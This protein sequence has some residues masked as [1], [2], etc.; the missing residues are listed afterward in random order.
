MFCTNTKTKLECYKSDD[1]LILY[2][3]IY[4]FLFLSFC[5]DSDEERFSF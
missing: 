4:F 3:R 2:K 5:I 1:D